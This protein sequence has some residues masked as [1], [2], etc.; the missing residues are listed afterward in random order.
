MSDEDV[1]L[2]KHGDVL[3]GRIRT[4]SI[5]LE[6]MGWVS[7]L[8][9]PDPNEILIQYTGRDSPESRFHET[10]HL[11]IPPGTVKERPVRYTNRGTAPPD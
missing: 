4:V 7:A 6:D 8:F 11:V 1:A 9:D 3:A 2:S 5:L 10:I